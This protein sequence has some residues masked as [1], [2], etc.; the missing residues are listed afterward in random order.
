MRSDS[1]RIAPATLKHRVAALAILGAALIAWGAA[2]TTP[3]AASHAAAQSAGRLPPK[4]VVILIVDQMR[5]DYVERFQRNWTGGLRRLVTEG[6]VF[7]RAAFPYLMT[8]TCP[9]HATLATGALPPEHGIFQNTWFDRASGSLTPCTFDPGV[10]GISYGRR[11]AGSHSPRH[12]QLPTLADGLRQERKAR[13]VS[14]SL[15]ARSAIMMAGR[16][17]DAVSWF[18]ETSRNWETSSAY[19]AAPVPAVRAFID[20]YPVE[21]DLG[22]VWT[23]LLPPDRYEGRDDGPGETPPVG[24][25][26]TFPHALRGQAGGAQPDDLFYTQWERSPFASEYLGRLAGALAESFGLGTRSDATDFLAVSFSSPD[27]IGHAFGP[28]SHEVQDL[29]AHLDRTIGALFDRLDTLV[30]RGGYV[31]GLS[32]DHG[33]ADLP[34][35]GT[36]QNVGGRLNSARIGELVDRVAGAD[37]GPGRFVAQAYGTDIYFAPGA[38]ERLAAQPAAMKAVVNAIDMQPGVAR[39][40]RREELAEGR[41]SSDAALR[42]AALSYVPRLSGDLVVLPEAG[43]MF[44]ASGTTHGSANAYD[45][46]V[47]FILAGPGVKPGRYTDEVTPAD[48]APTLAT[49]T[50]LALRRASGRVL[51]MALL[52]R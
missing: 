51:Q 35:E 10:R 40:F 17:G 16:G 44:T 24:W 21:A 36:G 43:W 13:V 7:E 37:I 29:Y 2:S 18:G 48:M 49:I 38:Y 22:K 1:S 5:G 20:K 31:V 39:V 26:R 14:L 6:A 19:A 47:P 9:G 8:L 30:G 23:Y 25:T 52:P 45:Q 28:H 46:R 32:A 34:H 11:Q 15:K 50:G 12:L 33:V 27:L 4:L 42:A 3:A 41:A